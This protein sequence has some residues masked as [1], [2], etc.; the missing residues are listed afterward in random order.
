MFYK[1]PSIE[2]F[3]KIVQ[4]T[5]KSMKFHNLEE[6]SLKFM[7]TTKL[8]GTNGSIGLVYEKGEP[9]Y[10]VQSRNNII[11]LENDNA[12]FAQFALNPKVKSF[13]KEK[14]EK[15]YNNLSQEEK[16]EVLSIFVYGEWGG[17]NIQ[18]GVAIT[19]MEKFFAPFDVA[20]Y[21]KKNKEDDNLNSENFVR[22][23]LDQKE[24]E[25]FK[26]EELRIFPIS[27]VVKPE[28]LDIKFD[29]I[30][31][32]KTSK[33]LENLTLEV[34]KEDPF[35]K[36]FGFSGIGEGIV[37]K[38]VYEEDYGDQFDL[39]KIGDLR[40][41]V[42]G[43][44]HAVSK[45]KTLAPVDFEKVARLSEAVDKYV[46]ENRLNQGI[47]YLNE[48]HKELIVENTSFFIQ[49][50]QK[51]ILKEEQEEIL[52]SNLEWKKLSGLI[53]KK[54]AEWFKKKILEET[55]K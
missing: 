37:W 28:Y 32:E 39:R 49:W 50:V 2:Q 7:G 20:I 15:I 10:Q 33:E 44:K 17:S 19:Q 24:V 45:V 29:A 41:K 54:V 18:K 46:T 6:I 16:D 11:T 47:D 4:N 3:N 48:M 51:D 42:K 23:W 38:V 43:E 8:H 53:A 30:S 9:V 26:N 31:L 34:E 27:T 13:M 14:I 25:E 5:K 55:F 12:F 35:A 21:F 22:K 40:F 36:H 1:Y 52:I